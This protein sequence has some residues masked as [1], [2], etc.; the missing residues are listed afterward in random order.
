M[1]KTSI[2]IKPCNIAQS[3]AHNRRDEKYL[4]SLNP[5]QIYIDT[6]LTP[7]NKSY[8][9]PELEFTSLQEYYEDLKAM[10]KEK[11]GR[12]MQEK[13]VEYTDK[14]GKKRVRKGSSPIREGVAVIEEGTTLEDL[15]KFTAA[16]QERWGIRAIQIHIHRDEGHYE[17]NERGRRIRVPN[18]HA[19]IVWDWMDHTTGKSHK[20]SEKD[21]SKMQDLLADMLKMERGQKKS[22]TGLEHLEREEFILKKLKNEQK[23]VKEKTEALESEIKGLDF[24]EE[25]LSVPEIETDSIVKKAKEA[26]RKELSI[27]VPV[28]GREKWREEREEALKTIMADMED[29]LIAA[30][31][32]QKRKILSYGKALYKQTKREIYKISE[33]NKRL[34]GENQRLTKENDNLRGKLASVDENAVR[35]LRSDLAA[36][37]QRAENA[38]LAVAQEKERTKQ[39]WRRA[40]Q[41]RNRAEKAEDQVREILSVPE[42]KQFWEMLLRQKAFLE[43]MN[44]RISKAVTALYDFA[45]NRDLI[46]SNEAEDSIANGIIAEAILKDLDPTEEGQR[47]KAAKNL[48]DKVNWKGTYQSSC[49]LAETRIEQLCEEITVSKEIVATLLLAAGGK[50]GVS[51]GG[52]GGG[53]NNE[54]TNWDGTKKKTG[55]SRSR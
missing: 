11:T 52:G 18:Y 40:E 15:K 30:K 8:V 1:S 10:V 4:K 55:W 20:L 50:G 21:M 29:D 13:D 26:I 27:P 32:S 42:I 36:A 2:H 23:A 44:R 14:N 34:K 53:S 28:M 6:Y 33:E 47:K 3:E 22:E 7:F 45:K 5:D 9:S 35:K 43:E 16:V 24:D 49:D 37:N 39:E 38:D 46:F 25:E 48:L 17:E 54:L 41:E 31:G 12:A 19:H 51:V